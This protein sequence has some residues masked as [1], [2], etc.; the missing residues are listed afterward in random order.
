MIDGRQ[1]QVVAGPS[2]RRQQIKVASC[3]PAANHLFRSSNVPDLL[4]ILVKSRVAIIRFGLTL[5][6]DDHA[7]FG[8]RRRWRGILQLERFRLMNTGN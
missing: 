8:S 7:T 3:Q 6:T 4:G 1:P 5:L 2:A